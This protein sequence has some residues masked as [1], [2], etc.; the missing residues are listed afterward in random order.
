MCMQKNLERMHESFMSRK[1]GHGLSNFQKLQKRTTFSKNLHSQYGMEGIQA[2]SYK[3]VILR[4]PFQ[5]KH[6]LS[7][8][9]ALHSL[10]I[11]VLRQ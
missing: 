4:S 10:L 5:K 11:K 1:S 8:L 3:E 2:L 9:T 7:T 6:P